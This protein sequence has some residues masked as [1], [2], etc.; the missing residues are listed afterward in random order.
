MS[1]TFVAFG[2][3]LSDKNEILEKLRMLR[4]VYG[5]SVLTP[6][7]D[8]RTVTAL[9]AES[10]S[11][12]SNQMQEAIAMARKEE[13]LQQRRAL[14]AARGL[15]LRHLPSLQP[16]EPIEIIGNLSGLPLERA[17]SI[18]EVIDQRRRARESRGNR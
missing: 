1:C 5:L 17:A 3:T 10:R 12:F 11:K 15:A 4:H 9:A 16:R 13:L 2:I 8:G 18:N 14:A 6:T 7:Q